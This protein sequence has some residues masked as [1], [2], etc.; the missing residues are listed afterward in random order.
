MKH[1][2]RDAATDINARFKELICVLVTNTRKR[3]IVISLTGILPS[4]ETFP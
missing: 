3:H 2:V 4:N 1:F